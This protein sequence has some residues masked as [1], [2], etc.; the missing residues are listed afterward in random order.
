MTVRP[1]EARY[2][3]LFVAVAATFV[4][5]LITANV[6][7]AKLVDVAGF[8]LPA[9]IVIFPISY[10]IGDV[11]TEVYGYSAARRVIWLGFGAN[12]LFVVAASIAGAMPAPGFWQHQSAYDQIL[13]QAPRILAA[14]FLAFLLGEF[15]NS[16]VLAKMKIMT[17]GRWLWT[18]TIGSTVVGQACDSAIFVTIAFAG[19]FPVSAIVGIVATQWIAKCLYETAATPLTYLVVNY[20]KRKEGVD[21]YDHDTR[22]NP[23]AVTT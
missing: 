14:S 10:V 3:G 16:Y 19:K 6:I 13:G 2:S 5:C 15:V 4:A 9:G 7:S 21:T 20:L 1:A 23:F 17:S 18:R 11:L 8:V 12:L 22:F